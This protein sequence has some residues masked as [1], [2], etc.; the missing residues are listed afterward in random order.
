VYS[1]LNDQT[2][3]VWVVDNASADGS[4]DLVKR[5]FPQVRLIVNETNQGF[6]RANNQAMRQAQGKTWVLLNPDTIVQPGAFQSLSEVFDHE[7]SVGV[8]G[9]Q[10]L[11]PD[12]S[13][14]PSFG[15]FSSPWT[16]FF[17]QFYL[18]K[19]LPSPFPLGKQVNSMQKKEYQQAKTVDWV[20]GACMAVSPEAA[21]RVGFFDE[22]L[23]M[24][25]EDMEFCWRVAQAG[26]STLF[27]PDAKVIHLSRQASR[28]EYSTWISRYTRGQ[29]MFIH[30]HR[31]K[32]EFRLAGLCVVLGSLI[33]SILWGGIK[34]IKPNRRLEA[35]QRQA[36]YLQ[37][38]KMGFQA[39]KGISP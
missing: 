25:G 38:M 30:R 13:I 22:T 19:F 17:F 32:V 33:R 37:A 26:Y 28:R 15:Q 34:I 8:V 16:E 20:S 10:L 3:E 4:A 23:F 5:E 1:A 18:Y 2:A 24:Y 9:P 14:Q 31:T 36:G 39:V 29:L 27:Y 21:R 35:N 12:R 6:S 7:T 11:N